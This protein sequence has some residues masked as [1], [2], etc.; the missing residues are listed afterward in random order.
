MPT[1]PGYGLYTRQTTPEIN[2]AERRED[3]PASRSLATDSTAMTPG[4]S[5]AVN[6][7]IIRFR[8]LWRVGFLPCNAHT[9]IRVCRSD[10]AAVGP[11]VCLSVCRL[12]VD[13]V[14]CGRQLGLVYGQNATDKMPEIKTTPDKMPRNVEM[15]AIIV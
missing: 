6:T 8:S 14:R 12:S 3:Y 11:S 7:D 13:D 10:C 2:P 1:C 15:Y 5:Q 9:H 4:D